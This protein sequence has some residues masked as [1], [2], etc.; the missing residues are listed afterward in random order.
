MGG[1]VQN[2]EAFVII[3]GL[4]HKKRGE[5]KYRDLLIMKLIFYLKDGGLRVKFSYPLDIQPYGHV[6]AEVLLDDVV[7]FKEDVDEI[8]HG[9][10]IACVDERPTWDGFVG[11]D[12][13]F[14]LEGAVAC[15]NEELVIVPLVL[16]RELHHMDYRI[17]LMGSKQYERSRLN[18]YS[19]NGKVKDQC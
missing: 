2:S 4:V 6:L 3:G 16:L 17:D 18:Q 15:R 14:D 10:R 12:G 13:G 11:E 7:I 5:L 9:H 8:A 1:K 19:K